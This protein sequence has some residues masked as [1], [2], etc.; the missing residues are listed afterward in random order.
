MLSAG[1]NDDVLVGGRRQAVG[2]LAIYPIRLLCYLVM[3]ERVGI[4]N[5]LK[6]QFIS[7]LRLM[8]YAVLFNIYQ[9]ILLEP[10]LR[11]DVRKENRQARSSCAK[12]SDF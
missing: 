1:A 3:H 10:K 5:S 6:S 7:T 11:C 9:N 2:Q 12:F 4:P 8:L